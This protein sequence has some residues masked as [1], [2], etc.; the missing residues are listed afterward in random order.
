MGCWSVIVGGYEPKNYQQSKYNITG[1]QISQVHKNPRLHLTRKHAS[2]IKR[3]RA[4]EHEECVG[5]TT[6]AH[7]FFGFWMGVAVSQAHMMD[8]Q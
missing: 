4:K 7:N 8:A 5:L 3:D 6:T 2:S 1:S